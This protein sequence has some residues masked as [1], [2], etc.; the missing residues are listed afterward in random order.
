MYEWPMKDPVL[1]EYEV[2]M[3]EEDRKH[4]NEKEIIPGNVK[5]IKNKDTVFPILRFSF[6]NRRSDTYVEG[7]AITETGELLYFKSFEASE[8]PNTITIS[9]YQKPEFLRLSP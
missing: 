3:S 9:K 2:E 4:R 8:V 5:E 6:H 7:A 1:H